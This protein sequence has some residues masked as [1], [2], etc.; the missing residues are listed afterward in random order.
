MADVKVIVPDNLGKTIVKDQIVPDK[1]DVKVNP[2]QLEVTEQG[3]SIKA[4]VIPT[5]TTVTVSAPLTGNGSAGSPISVNKD[6]LNRLTDGT[7]K[8]V[9]GY[10]IPA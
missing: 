2:N 9:L 1:W 6:S 10:I 8:V 3:I 4:G 5:T 7:G